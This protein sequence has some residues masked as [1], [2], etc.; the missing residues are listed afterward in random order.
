MGYSRDE[1]QERCQAIADFSELGDTIQYPVKSYS[2]GMLMRLGFACS[3]FVEPDIL[4]VDEALAVGDAYFQTK[5]FYKIK[6]LIDIGTTFIYVS[7]GQDAVRSLCNKGILLENGRIIA[8]GTAKDVAEIYNSYVHAKMNNSCMGGGTA[9]HQ[10]LSSENKP[11]SI[12]RDDLFS[13]SEEFSRRVAALRQGNGQA[14]FTDVQLL[15]DS[16]E[17]AQDFYP[18]ETIT[19]RLSFVA[20][21]PLTKNIGVGIAVADESGNEILQC[22]NSDYGVFFDDQSEESHY[23]VE[24]RFKNILAYGHYSLI[25]ALDWIFPDDRVPGLWYTKGNLDRCYGSAIFHCKEDGRTLPRGKVS[26]HFDVTII[27]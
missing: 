9:N 24:Y 19:V 1:M 27:E 15:S 26:H 17:I 22:L 14:H 13:V 21:M 10:R 4:V 16:G 18:G 25:T 6:E 20:H 23:V 3:V 8:E 12:S 11:R 5:C 2:S 7:H